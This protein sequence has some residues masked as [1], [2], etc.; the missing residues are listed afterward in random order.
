[1][2]SPVIL[3]AV[4]LAAGRTAGAAD[5]SGGN[6]ATGT[7]PSGEQL[8]SRALRVECVQTISIP[9][10]TKSPYGYTPHDGM[11][12]IGLGPQTLSVIS[13]RPPLTFATVPDNRPFPGGGVLAGMGARPAKGQVAKFEF[14]PSGE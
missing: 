13:D 2:R 14:V 5:S 7:R 11:K 1:M 6:G 10:D 8:N 4:A 12:A 3:V 9:F